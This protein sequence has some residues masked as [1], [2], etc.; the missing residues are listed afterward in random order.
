M[1]FGLSFVSSFMNVCLCIFIFILFWFTSEDNFI[2]KFGFKTGFYA[3]MQ[4]VLILER[5]V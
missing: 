5:N 1:L 3:S 2:I 4:C